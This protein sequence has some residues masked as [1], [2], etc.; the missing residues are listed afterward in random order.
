MGILE[1][2]LVRNQ[3]KNKALEKILEICLEIKNKKF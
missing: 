1:Q 3:I 2:P